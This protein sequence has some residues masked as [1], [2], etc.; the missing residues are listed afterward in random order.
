[1]ALALA[2]ATVVAV[3]PSL[4][5]APNTWERTD[6]LITSHQRAAVTLAGPRCGAN[7]G[8][9]LMAAY[10]YGGGEPSTAAELYDP[11]TD[12]WAS[13]APM[14]RG[15]TDITLTVLVGTKCGANCGKVL[16]VG[17]VYS[18]GTLIDV[19]TAELFDPT[20]GAESWALAGRPPS[21][22]ANGSTV[23][24]T[25]TALLDGDVLVVDSQRGANVF[26]SATGSWRLAPRTLGQHEIGFNAT[27][28]TGN[29][30]AAYCGD[31]L[32]TGGGSG[33]DGG[34]NVQSE[35]FDPGTG[36]WAPTA[37]LTTPRAA[38]TATLLPNGQVLLAGGYAL[39]NTA[40]QVP[41]VL[42]DVFD[43]PTG[44]WAPGPPMNQPRAGHTATLTS[45][46]LV[47]A[48]GYGRIEAGRLLLSNPPEIYVL[49]R[50]W[51]AT[52]LLAQPRVEHGAAL[53]D[54]G[55]VLV[56]G[57]QG[58]DPTQVYDHA[59]VV[60]STERYTPIP[61]TVVP[62]P[63]PI[64]VP[65]V[66]VPPTTVPP[67]LPGPRPT[68]PPGAPPPPDAPVVTAVD[69]GS[70][71]VAGG[72]RV[73]VSGIRLAGAGAVSFGSADVTAHPCPP[74]GPQAGAPCFTEESSTR[75]VAYSPPR[76]R[77]GAVHVRVITDAGTS[78]ESGADVFEYTD[79]PPA[80]TGSQAFSAP[81]LAAPPGGSTVIP[82]PPGGSP[83]LSPSP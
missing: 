23:G 19:P 42:T 63:T 56:A 54:D 53:L 16:A 3:A 71:P 77:P 49:N 29:G 66:T 57:G 13:T 75:L 9:V 45:C 67:V 37:P 80:P 78:A 47:V 39:Q 8:K 5:A 51:V 11:S 59:V 30:C 79:T 34:T 4:A 6:D 64:T 26:D 24:H 28:I 31:V 58:E 74:G 21:F 33:L 43:P 70:G 36:T 44:Q 25:A 14:Q 48:G 10:K 69:P 32:V 38:S 82:A 60:N 62:D 83:A 50:G 27:L 2:V 20:P 7:C 22:P 61:C 40:Q 65:P 35:A 41:S 18:P 73:A 81:G 55:S 12:T 17:Y 68:V 52:G 46:G 72:T 1:M 76:A 15:G